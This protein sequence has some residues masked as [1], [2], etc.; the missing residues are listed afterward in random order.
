[1]TKRK[2]ALSCATGPFLYDRDGDPWEVLDAA[3]VRCV[4]VDYESPVPGRPMDRNWVEH[5]HGP[6]VPAVRTWDLPPEPGPEV[7]AVRTSYGSLYRRCA[8]GWRLDGR[9]EDEEGLDWPYLMSSAYP[10]T[11]A[12]HELAEQPT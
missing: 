6:L 9:P 2:P 7:R 8:T 12:T 1:V 3:R 4:S 11:D 10:L 5:E